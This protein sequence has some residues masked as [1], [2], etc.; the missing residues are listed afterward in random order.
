MGSMRR[1]LTLVGLGQVGKGGRS[2]VTFTKHPL[3]PGTDESLFTPHSNSSRHT[4]PP[5]SILQITKLSSRK[6]TGVG[7]GP[8]SHSLVES[9][10]RVPLTPESM[11]LP[12]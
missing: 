11:L 3:Y 4:V 5:S 10:F 7:L 12:K 1:F 8:H 9:K 6:E 2:K